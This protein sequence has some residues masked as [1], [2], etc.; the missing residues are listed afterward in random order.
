MKTCATKGVEMKQ[1]NLQVLERAIQVVEYLG[2]GEIDEWRSL[3]EVAAG[4]GMPESACYRILETLTAW[5]WIDKSPRGKG[6]RI[7][8]MHLIGILFFIQDYYKQKLRDCGGI[9]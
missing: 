3:R 5:N 6:Y 7:G 9:S 2:S 8:S 1:G 4:T